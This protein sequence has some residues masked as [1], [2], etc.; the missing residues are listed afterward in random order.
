MNIFSIVLAFL[1][2][3]NAA[4]GIY[5]RNQQLDEAKRLVLADQLAKMAKDGKV[6]DE[7]EKRI[8]GLSDPAVIDELS[9]RGDFRD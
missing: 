8:S 6:I 4:L 7:V 9:K 1:K 5:T 2:L 3:A